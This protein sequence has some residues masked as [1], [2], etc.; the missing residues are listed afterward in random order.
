MNV[1]IIVRAILR[2]ITSKSSCWES[3]RSSAGD[4]ICLAPLCLN[5]YSI[6]YTLVSS[7][8]KGLSK[9]ISL[10]FKAFSLYL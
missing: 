6:Q 2:V 10:S 5:T 7:G 3:G 8:D 9:N 4:R 1:V